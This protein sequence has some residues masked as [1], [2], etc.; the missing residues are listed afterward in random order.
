MSEL[1]WRYFQ[2]L[3]GDFRPSTFY[4]L[5][6]EGEA[7]RLD[8]AGA[9]WIATD[10]NAILDALDDGSAMWD[11]LSPLDFRRAVEAATD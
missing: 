2:E 9:R 6:N 5:S 8:L 3:D 7:Q 4:R 11:E 10:R 1:T